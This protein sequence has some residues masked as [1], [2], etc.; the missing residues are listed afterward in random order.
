IFDHA[1]E[2]FQTGHRATLD[3]TLSGGGDR[4]TY[5]LSGSYTDHQGSIVGNS[6]LDKLTLRLKATQWIRDNLSVS[7]SFS[8]ADQNGD[9]IQ[10]GSN[11]SGLLLGAFR[12]VPEFNNL[13]YLDPETG[14]HR[15][16]RNPE[17]TELVAGRGYD[18]PFWIANEILNTT[19]VGRTFGNIR[20]DWQALDWLNVTGL[21]GLDYANDDRT[22]LFPKSSSESPQGRVI[23]GTFRTF[24][25]DGSLLATAERTLTDYASGSLSLG[26]NLRQSEVTTNIVQGDNLIFQAEELDFAVDRLP[27]EFKSR[28][29]T[30]GYF[31]E[32]NLDLWDQLFLSGRVRNEGSSTF[33][34][35]TDGRFW[36]PSLS[37]AWTFSKLE[38]LQ[39]LDWLTFGKL[40]FGYGVAGKAPP[41][42]SNVASFTTATFGD[43]WL[44]LGLQSIYMGREGVV[45]EPSLPNTGI[46][47]ERTRETEVGLDVAFLNSRVS[48]GVTRY[49][50]KTE[51]AILFVPVPPSTGF[52]TV[53]RNGAEFEN[54][55][56]E[57]TL[58][59]VP[60]QMEN[61]SWELGAQWSRN[62]SK[63]LDILGSEGVGIGFGFFSGSN[64]IVKDKCGVTADQPCPFGVIWGQDWVRFGRGIVIDGENI[65]EAFPEAPAGA[66]YIDDDGFPIEDAQNRVIGDP[67]PDWL[68]SI[69]STFR[70][71]NN[72]RISALLDIKQGGDTWNGTKGALFYFGTHKETLPF[73]GEGVQD[74]VFAGYGPGAGTPVDLNWNTWGPNGPGTGF[75]GPGSQFVEE[76]SYVKLRDISVTYA[77]D[78]EWVNRLGF[79]TVE[80]TLSGRNLKTWTDYTG[81]DPET[82]LTGQTI[83]RGLDYFGHPQTRS[84][85]LQFNFIR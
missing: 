23:R 63:V 48:V 65:D 38:T 26:Y 39:E 24:D 21:A 4:T 79:N 45:S 20:T 78:Q 83:G 68:G 72:L 14:L 6:E 50:Q 29:R 61:F 74:T 59:V 37:A 80:V 51:D 31:A 84:W 12:T 32:A 5:Y 55:G 71:Y 7:G 8:Y 40:R 64:R 41:V 11:T 54:K 62:R 25:V 30:D 33:G 28:V 85:I 16:Y 76:S 75:T 77:F 73:H 27:D 52:S 69:R 19:D 42:F 67:N 9:L 70:V 35:D 58:D 34:P 53:P 1:N 82:N 47:P 60:I 22:T 66:I 18:N 36:Y 13:P 15:S 3:F 56:W 10:A 49:A 17:P 46:E 57:V 43:G 2:I 44:N 81:I